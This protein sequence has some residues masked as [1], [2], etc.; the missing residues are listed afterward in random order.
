MGPTIFLVISKN[1][2]KPSGNIKKRGPQE[3]C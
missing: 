3:R 1:I 2:I